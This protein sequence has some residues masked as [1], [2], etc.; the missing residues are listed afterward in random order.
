MKFDLTR[1][2][3]F[4]ILA[5]WLIATGLIVLLDISFDGRDTLMAVLA[6]AAGVLILVQDYRISL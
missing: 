6:I 5:V 1:E 3:G 4:K 2:L